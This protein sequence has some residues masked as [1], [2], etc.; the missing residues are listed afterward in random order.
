MK[1]IVYISSPY[2]KGDSALN[3][4][5]QCQI[6]NELMD[7]GIVLPI[8]PLWSHF[9]HSIFPRSYKDWMDY[10]LELIKICDVCLRVDVAI[11]KMDYYITESL[12]A[13]KEVIAFIDAGK[14]VFY[15]KNEMYNWL[16]E[17]WD[18]KEK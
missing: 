10:D 3:T 14:R 2:T 18:N 7:D 13:D 17:N 8:A 9:Q 4:R 15:D 5:F 11:P 12:G 1:P 6:W 16:V